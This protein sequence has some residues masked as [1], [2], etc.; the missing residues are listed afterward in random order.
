[1]LHETVHGCWDQH[2]RIL[3]PGTSQPIII[4]SVSLTDPTDRVREAVSAAPAIHHE[5]M[6]NG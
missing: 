4:L 2:Q 1:M 6:M 3:G 5:F